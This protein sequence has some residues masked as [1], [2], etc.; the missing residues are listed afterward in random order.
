MRLQI[1]KPEPVILIGQAISSVSAGA[2]SGDES[3]LGQMP[4]AGQT[5]AAVIL[6]CY[7]VPPVPCAVAVG[8]C[9]IEH[10]RH[11]WLAPLR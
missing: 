3:E 1:N 8:I 6:P 7:G 2:K 5:L 10:R 9:Q 4:E 11:S